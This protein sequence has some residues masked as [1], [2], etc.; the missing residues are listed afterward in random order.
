[1]LGS[2]D[3]D[4]E[5]Q[6]IALGALCALLEPDDAVELFKQETSW[7][8][9]LVRSLPALVHESARS[10]SVLDILFDALNLSTILATHPMF[11]HSPHDE[12]LWERLLEHAAETVRYEPAAGLNWACLAASVSEKHEVARLLLRN[13]EVKRTL[14]HLA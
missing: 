6:Q 8:D 11:V 1:M 7:Y 10:L 14:V 12:W 9:V 4:Y 3:L 5:Q 13:A 2:F